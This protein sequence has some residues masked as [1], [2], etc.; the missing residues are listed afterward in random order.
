VLRLYKK[1]DKNSK[2][3]DGKVGVDYLKIKPGADG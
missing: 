3:R 2:R 1:Y